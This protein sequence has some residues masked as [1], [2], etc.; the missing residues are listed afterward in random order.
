MVLVQD[1]VTAVLDGAV[2]GLA[3]V[4]VQNKIAAVLDGAVHG[5]AVVLLDHWG[6]A[7]VR[8]HGCGIELGNGSRKDLGKV[9]ASERK[10]MYLSAR[11]YF[12]DSLRIRS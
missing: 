8:D 4:L 2:Y 11:I 6:C 9:L 5:L 10:G 1:K 7:D 12:S 3:M